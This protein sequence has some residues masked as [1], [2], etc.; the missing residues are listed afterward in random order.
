MEETRFEHAIVIRQ[1]DDVSG[2]ILKSEIIGAT[3]ATDNEYIVYIHLR[4]GGKVEHYVD[5]D[6]PSAMS[7][8][9]LRIASEMGWH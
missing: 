2:I 9:I 3:I 5:A 7:D 4:N 1:Y 8:E 6:D